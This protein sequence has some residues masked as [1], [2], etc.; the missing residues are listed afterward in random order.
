MQSRFPADLDVLLRK[1]G[2]WHSSVA[3]AEL[4]VGLGRLDPGHPASPRAVRQIKAVIAKVPSQRILNPTV[5]IWREAA[6]AAGL[7]ARLQGFPASRAHDILNDALI[8]FDARRHGRTV[9]TRNVADFDLLQ[10][11]APEGQVL[12]YR[13]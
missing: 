9:L 7:M 10:Q 11:L 3:V 2:L 5:A 4:A 1:C 6:I 12:F 8:S 13:V